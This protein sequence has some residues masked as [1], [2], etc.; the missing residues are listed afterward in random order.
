MTM[1][2]DICLLLALAAPVRRPRE[3]ITFIA[4]LFFGHYC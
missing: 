3:D 4:I 1:R 2:R